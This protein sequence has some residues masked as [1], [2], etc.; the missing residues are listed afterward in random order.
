MTGLLISPEVRREKEVDRSSEMVR[1]TT[2][3]EGK[4]LGYF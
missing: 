4:T 1:L 3:P 2:P